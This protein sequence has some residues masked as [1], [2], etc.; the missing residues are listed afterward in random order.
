METTHMI[1]KIAVALAFAASLATI[2]AAQAAPVVTNSNAVKAAAPGSLT[3]VRWGWW[4]PVAATAG[5]ALGAA[6]A[7]SGCGWYGCG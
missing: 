4:V 2:G 3:E 5:L 6:L 7:A 1:R